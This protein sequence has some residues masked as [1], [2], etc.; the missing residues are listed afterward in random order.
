MACFALIDGNSFYVSCET[1]FQPHLAKI[2]VVVL[3]NN[4]GCIVAANPVAKALQSELGET[5]QRVNRFKPGAPMPEK[6][7]FQPYFKVKWLL[8][9]HNAAVFSSNYELYADMSAR[10]HNLI[11]QFSPRQ[12]I[13]SIDESFLELTGVHQYNLTDY[14]HE[15]K[16][17][18]KQGLGLPVAVGI[19]HSKTQAKLA[20]HL[21]KKVT[22]YDNVLDLT[23]LSDGALDA[24]L[25]KVDIDDLWGI[26]RR[27]SQ[28]LK[29]Q[30][31]TTARQLK[32]VNLKTIRKQ[33]GVVMER[34]VREL[35]GEACLSLEEVADNK[36]QI[37]ASRSFS[38]EVTDLKSLEQAV[39]TYASRAAE[40]LRRQ[41]SVCQY[42]TVFVQTNRFKTHI[43]QYQNS[44]TFPMIYGSD[45]SILLAKLARCALKKIYHPSH[46]YHKAGII[47]SD[48]TDKDTLQ[49]D[50]FAPDPKYSGNPK[51]DKLM[52]LMD[53]LNQTQ[54]KNTLYLASAGIPEK[55]D[56]TMKR[57]RLSPRYTTRWNEL[58]VVS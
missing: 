52:A 4:D 32:H 31:I 50:L 48:I 56:W 47:L 53:Q 28:R 35:N 5:A 45:S 3:S 22:A 33:Y 29:A 54:G 37:I 40:K 20:N 49:P 18:I 9:K 13:Y 38:H 12:E 11:G 58:M 55:R 42:V 16:H 36:K 25:H 46:A 7:M 2:P 27:L 34:L 6:L 39:V 26:G 44:H 10:M 15:I 8:D 23:A 43:T 19:G 24:I 30:G 41:H 14:G 21:A 57:D 51:Q 17:T 1:V